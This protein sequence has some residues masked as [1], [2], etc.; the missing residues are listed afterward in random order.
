MA[1]CPIRCPIHGYGGNRLLSG[2]VASSLCGGLR[3]WWRIPPVP[4]F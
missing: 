3:R 2:S 4:L 1:V